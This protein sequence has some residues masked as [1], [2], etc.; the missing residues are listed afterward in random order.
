MTIALAFLVFVAL[1]LLYLYLQASHSL[2]GYKGRVRGSPI[3]AKPIF[4]LDER[5]ALTRYGPPTSTTVSHIAGIHVEGGISDLESWILCNYAKTS[6][7]IFELGTATGKT[8][9]RR[10]CR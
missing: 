9:C 4:D 2:A 1:V 8:T 6:E 3:P 5:F 10:S 7:R